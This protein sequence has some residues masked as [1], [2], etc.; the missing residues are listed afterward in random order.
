MKHG[1]YRKKPLYANKKKKKRVEKTARP[2]KEF[3]PDIPSPTNVTRDGHTTTK[4]VEKLLETLD[5]SEKG[6][7]NIGRTLGK[8]AGEDSDTKFALGKA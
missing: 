7:K 1:S 4:G 3:P 6:R 2:K 5:G 8:R